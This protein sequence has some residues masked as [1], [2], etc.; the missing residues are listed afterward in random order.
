MITVTVPR[1]DELT[2]HLRAICDEPHM[3][4]LYQRV[5]RNLAGKELT[6]MG[7]GNGLI[8]AWVD[9]TADLPTPVQMT[10]KLLLPRFIPACTDDPD[11]Q[12]EAREHL[13][14]AGFSVH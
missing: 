4:T 13:R 5:V 8:F 3:D 10:T 7:I 2:A 6:G 11:V 12:A 9:Y 1:G 14:A